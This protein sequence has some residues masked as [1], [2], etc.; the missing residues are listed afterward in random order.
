MQIKTNI[1]QAVESVNFIETPLSIISIRKD[2]ILEIRFKQDDYEV[3]VYAQQEIHEAFLKLTDNG[4][5]PYHVLIIPG[6]YGGVTKEAREKEA[7]DS[8]GFQNQHS[9]CVV[10]PALAQRILGTMYLS[11]KKKKPK[12]PFKL[13]NSETT[14]V[15]WILDQKKA[16]ELPS[17]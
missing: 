14:A 11:L 15:K 6:K 13:F 4:R 9:M 16:V 1:A 5:I 2:G 7:F 17:S 3:D 10:T 8:I 12:Y